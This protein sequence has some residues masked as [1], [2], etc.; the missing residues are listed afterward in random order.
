[1][2][3]LKAEAENHPEY[4]I[5]SDDYHLY[6]AARDFRFDALQWWR[7]HHSKYSLADSVLRAIQFFLAVPAGQNAS[8][9]GNSFAGTHSS[10]EMVSHVGRR[11]LLLFHLFFAL[12]IFLGRVKDK[13]M[14]KLSDEKMQQRTF[15]H[16]LYATVDNPMQR[17]ESLTERVQQQL[18]T[19]RLG[20]STIEPGEPAQV[21]DGTIQVSSDDDSD[22]AWSDEE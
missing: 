13:S 15:L 20:E 2:N 3:E 12:L 5:F 16:T 17:V 18:E 10:F 6:T 9:S 8:E 1:M 7:Q 19:L 4:E 22:E 21:R 11:S 14:G